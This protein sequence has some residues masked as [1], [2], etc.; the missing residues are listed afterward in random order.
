M[1]NY[2]GFLHHM[3]GNML[4]IH[5]IFVETTLVTSVDNCVKNSDNWVASIIDTLRHI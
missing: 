5:N 2:L 3:Q 1:H 4:V